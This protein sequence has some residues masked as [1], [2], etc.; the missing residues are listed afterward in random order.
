RVSAWRKPS[1][2]RISRTLFGARAGLYLRLRSRM[3]FHSACIERVGRAIHVIFSS[4][5]ARFNLRFAS[6]G[7]ATVPSFTR[8]TLR[9]MTHDDI[10]CLLGVSRSFR[11]E[12]ARSSR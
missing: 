3:E 5:F 6:D 8:G 11:Q 12:S 1:S 9:E 7:R 4:A 10:L 2:A